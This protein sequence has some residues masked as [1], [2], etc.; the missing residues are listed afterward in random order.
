MVNI[1]AIEKVPGLVKDSCLAMVINILFEKHLKICRP[2]NKDY[3]LTAAAG[4]EG[5]AIRRQVIMH[6]IE[7]TPRRK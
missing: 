3:V 5:A 1:E 2:C 7:S 6:F 4:I